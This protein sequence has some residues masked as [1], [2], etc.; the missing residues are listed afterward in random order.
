MPWFDVPGRASAGTPIICGHWAA[1][2]LLLRDDVLGLDSG[3]VWGRQLSA[4]R[5]EDRRLYQWDC[6]AL[7]GRVFEE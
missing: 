1:L 6:Q 4:I 7:R 3:C 5:L 2:G